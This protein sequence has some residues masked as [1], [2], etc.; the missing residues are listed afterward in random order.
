MEKFLEVDGIRFQ[1]H[2]ICTAH[3]RILLLQGESAHLGCGYFSLAAADKFGDRFAVVSG[4]RD[5]SELLEG[6]VVAASS[7]ALACG[8][9]PGMSGRAALLLMEKR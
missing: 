5:F 8:V 9:E 7:A 6:H 1:M 2:D 4:V 3:S